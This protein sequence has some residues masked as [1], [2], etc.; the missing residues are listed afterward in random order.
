MQPISQIAQGELTSEPIT[1]PNFPGPGHICTKP[2]T[3]S[4]LQMLLNLVIS[5]L[6]PSTYQFSKR[7]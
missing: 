5:V 1:F 3:L 4:V 6:D 2:L 7:G